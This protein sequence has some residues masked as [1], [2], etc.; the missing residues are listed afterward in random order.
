ME[1][2]L[3]NNE[4]ALS[5][6]LSIVFQYTKKPGVINEIAKLIVAFRGQA[7]ESWSVLPSA[8]RSEKVFQKERVFLREFIR[9]IPNECSD[10]SYFDILVKAQHFGIPTRLLD[11]TTNP[12]VA[13]FFACTDLKDKDGAVYITKPDSA[14][15]QSEPSVEA[16]MF[17]LFDH[18]MGTDWTSH[19][20]SLLAKNL[21][22]N[23]LFYSSVDGIKCLDYWLDSKT[24]NPLFILPKLTNIRVRAQQG[25]FALYRTSLV[26]I[27][28]PNGITQ[29]K[30]LAPKEQIF[31]NP[32]LCKIII[33]ASF[34]SD[35]LSKLKVLGISK[36]TLFPGLEENIQEIVSEIRNQ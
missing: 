36:S 28:Q 35:L 1:I 4:S 7:D 33:P 34:K 15:F 20:T 18:K 24:S 26:E 12:L 10:L 32:F 14:F 23:V 8:F 6:Y 9:Q 29:K 13:L 30:F 11:L 21:T 5:E 25:L 31:D 3:S 27:R 16:Q 17:Y 2:K 22:T 19:Q